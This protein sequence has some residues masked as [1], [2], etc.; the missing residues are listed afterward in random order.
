M[1]PERVCSVVDVFTPIP[2]QLASN[3]HAQL[4]LSMVLLRVLIPLVYAR[5]R[6]AAHD[7]E[8]NHGEKTPR[9]RASHGLGSSNSPPDGVDTTGD[10]MDITA[11]DEAAASPTSN[12]RWSPLF[13]G[14]V[15]PFSILLEVPGLTEHWYIKTEAN[16]IVDIQGNPTILD[17]GLGLSMA[18]A[19]AANL[20]L[21]ARFM[22]RRVKAMTLLCIIFLSIHGTAFQVL[23]FNSR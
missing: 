6:R 3:Q 4:L 10:I 1:R 8:L 12:F 14:V 15:I 2:T 7:E 16:K 21:L 22:E 18:S 5:Q 13:A 19:V 23:Y 11:L 17:V 9:R 20:C